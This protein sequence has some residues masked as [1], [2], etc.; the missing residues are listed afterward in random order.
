MDIRHAVGVKVGIPA[1]KLADVTSYGS[2]PHFTEGEKAALELSEH[3]TRD[4]QVVSDECFS[5]VRQ[6]FSDPEIVELVFIIGYQTFASKFA[7]AFQLPP[8]GF[9]PPNG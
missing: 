2:S 4:D 1:E 5:R 9:S 3:I 8:Q 6:H 7:K